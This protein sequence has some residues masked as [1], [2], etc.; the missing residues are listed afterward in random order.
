[1]LENFIQVGYAFLT[2]K[3]SFEIWTFGYFGGQFRVSFFRFG[4]GAI[5]RVCLVLILG[6]VLGFG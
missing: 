5:F 3:N 2:H 6:R 4:W 1:M